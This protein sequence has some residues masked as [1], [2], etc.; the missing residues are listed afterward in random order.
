MKSKNI[1]RLASIVVLI[2][3]PLF[4]GCYINRIVELDSEIQVLK[5]RVIKIEK[6]RNDEKQQTETRM[7]ALEDSAKNNSSRIDQLMQ[8]ISIVGGKIEEEQINEGA[9]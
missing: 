9:K 1:K 3:L 5:G 7:K 8:R 4:S 6:D 2:F